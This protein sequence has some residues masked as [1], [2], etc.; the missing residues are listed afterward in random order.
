[1][2]WERLTG[3]RSY[4]LPM[5]GDPPRTPTHRWTQLDCGHRVHHALTAPAP[6]CVKCMD[7]LVDITDSLP[8][9]LRVRLDETVKRLQGKCPACGSNSLFI[10][11]GGWATCSISDCPNPTLASDTEED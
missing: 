1:M 2:D 5:P 8:A 11:S 10:A 3:T 9:R 6:P 7:A 4:R